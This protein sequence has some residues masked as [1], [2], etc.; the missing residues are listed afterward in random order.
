MTEFAK[1]DIFFA[2]ATVGFVVLMILLAILL[3]YAIKFVRTLTRIAE[4]VEEETLSIKEN[5]DSVR[6]KVTDGVNGLLVLLLQAIK[7]GKR[8]LGKKKK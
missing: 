4:I 2:V 3:V 7:A 8:L 1:M 5:M 6:E